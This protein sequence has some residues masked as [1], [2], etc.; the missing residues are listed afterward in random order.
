VGLMAYGPIRVFA[1]PA[2]R[3]EYDYNHDFACFSDINHRMGVIAHT[4]AISRGHQRT[5]FPSDHDERPTIRPGNPHRRP[6]PMFAPHAMYAYQPPSRPSSRASASQ[7][8]PK[9]TDSIQKSQLGRSP[10]QSLS[11]VACWS[12]EPG[13]GP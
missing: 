1:L 11:G 2:G 5:W 13:L 7:P 4:A 8:L 6:L 3:I 10:G 12:H 9:R